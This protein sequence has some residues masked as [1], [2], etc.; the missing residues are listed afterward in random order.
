MRAL[1]MR[2]DINDLFF[3]GGTVLLTGGLWWRYGGDVALIALG[4]VFLAVGVVFASRVK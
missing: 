2:L 1:L 3:F 4:A